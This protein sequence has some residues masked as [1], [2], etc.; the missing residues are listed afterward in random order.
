MQEILLKIRYFE[1]EL[2]KTVIFS[3]EP[4]PLKHHAAGYVEILSHCMKLV[5]YY[6]IV[7]ASQ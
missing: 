6:G 5:K 3:F 1:K 4:S 2:S 7:V